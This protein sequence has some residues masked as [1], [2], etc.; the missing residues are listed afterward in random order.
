MVIFMVLYIFSLLLD[1]L[2]IRMSLNENEQQF[3]VFFFKVGLNLYFIY[4]SKEAGV[5]V[6]RMVEI[7]FSFEYSSD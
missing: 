5:M 1:N 2:I 3:S 4:F 6:P 7:F